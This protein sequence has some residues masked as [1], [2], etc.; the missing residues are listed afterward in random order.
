MDRE[1]KV[2][3][4]EIRKRS[5][6][7]RKR[8]H[9]SLSVKNCGKDNVRKRERGNGEEIVLRLS[10][11]HE[12]YRLWL[13]SQNHFIVITLRVGG[14]LKVKEKEREKREVYEIVNRL[15]RGRN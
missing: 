10:V 2:H 3:V 13:I 4:Q 5:E 15:V 7:P 6:S 9:K 12:Y 8:L 14:K 11:H 1:T